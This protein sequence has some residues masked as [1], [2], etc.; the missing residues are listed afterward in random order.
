MLE[1]RENILWQGDSWIVIQGGLEDWNILIVI[2]KK[3]NLSDFTLIFVDIF[4][5]YCVLGKKI[6]LTIAFL[7]GKFVPNSV[8]L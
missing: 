2:F 1:K 4:G 8:A 7:T 5:F 6:K 3:E